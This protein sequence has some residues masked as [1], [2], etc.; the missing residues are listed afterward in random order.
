ML[1]QDPDRLTEEANL[2]MSIPHLY[3]IDLCEM[4]VSGYTLN[5]GQAIIAIYQV[6]RSS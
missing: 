4:S 2:G 6:L 1:I 5:Q 3:S